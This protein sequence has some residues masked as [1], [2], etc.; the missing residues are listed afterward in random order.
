MRD[1]WEHKE[2]KTKREATK[3]IHQIEDF[4]T[5]GENAL[6]ITFYKRKLYW[7]F[8][9]TKV[10]KLADGRRIRRVKG[11]WHCQDIRDNELFIEKLS[12]K[13]T[14]IQGF[15]GTLCSVDEKEYLVRRINGETSPDVTETRDCQCALEKSLEKLIRALGWKDFELLCDLIFA[16][17]GGQRVSVVGGTEKSIDLDLQMPI[18]GKRAFVQIK[19]QADKSTY[20]EYCQRFQELGQYDE[21]FFV[22]HSP[23]GEVSDWHQSDKIKLLLAANIAKLAVSAGLTGWLIAKN[24]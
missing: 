4:Y 5:L 20:D 13:L 6:W 2:N 24:S 7:C 14:R 11:N 12:G 10:E 9:E 8:A 23:S 1:Y 18:T 22:V 19:A 16:R 17:S 15:R 3:I 21:M